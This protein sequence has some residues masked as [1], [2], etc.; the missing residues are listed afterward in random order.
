LKSEDDS[1][2][3]KKPAASE[4]PT[5]AP[6]FSGKPVSGSVGFSFSAYAKCP[7]VRTFGT[8]RLPERLIPDVCIC[9]ASFHEAAIR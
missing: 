9:A 7:A 2:I 6:D 4:R 8:V 3:R 5:T 1:G